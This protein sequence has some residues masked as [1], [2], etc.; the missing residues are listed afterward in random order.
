MNY[1]AGW[2]TVHILGATGEHERDMI[3]KRTKEALAAAK[4]RGVVLGNSNVGRMNSEAAMARDA[5][6][7]PN[8]VG[9]VVAPRGSNCRYMS[10]VRAL[11][12]TSGCSTRCC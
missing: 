12:D 7:K 6:L 3:G 4:Q 5:V 8:D 9:N 2:L 11:M 10:R 1:G